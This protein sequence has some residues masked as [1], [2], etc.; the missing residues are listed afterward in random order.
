MSTSGIAHCTLKPVIVKHHCAKPL[1]IML[2]L[3]IR[4]A[5]KQKHMC[6]LH[7]L[8]MMMTTINYYICGRYCVGH[9]IILMTALPSHRNA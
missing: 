9:K 5:T 1:G 3:Y 8:A 7:T 6:T 2:T 4:V